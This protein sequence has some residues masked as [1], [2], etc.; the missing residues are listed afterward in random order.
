MQITQLSW[1]L[2]T[3]A[4]NVAPFDL[5]SYDSHTNIYSLVIKYSS[6][7]KCLNLFLLHNFKRI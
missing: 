4:L 2:M 6:N 5:K 7:N 3:S 1:K